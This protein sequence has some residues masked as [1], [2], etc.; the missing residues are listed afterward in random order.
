MDPEY[1]KLIRSRTE[2][3]AERTRVVGTYEDL[4]VTN[5]MADL[6]Q[7]KQVV[8]AINAKRKVRG[9]GGGEGDRR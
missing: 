6:L 2:R 8:T 1:A 7:H 4:S 3:A 9:Q 5:R